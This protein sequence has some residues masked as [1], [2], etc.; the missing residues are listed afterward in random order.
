MNES[1]KN[2]KSAFNESVVIY[3]I[4]KVRLPVGISLEQI[5]TLVFVYLFFAIFYKGINLLSYIL[6]FGYF[7]TWVILPLIIS[8]FIVKLKHDGKKIYQFV[9]DYLYW[10]LTIS[11]TKKMYCYDEE[12]KYMKDD[13]QMI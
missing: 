2:Y 3:S 1:F 8:Y 9:Y 6:P 7:S 12:V 10:K 13:I 4:G 5:L 11:M